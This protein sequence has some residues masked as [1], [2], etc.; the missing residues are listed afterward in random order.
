MIERLDHFVLT[1]ADLDRSIGFY[2]DVLG[3]TPRGFGEGR[4]ALHFGGQKINLHVAGKEFEPKARKPKPGSADLC[5]VVRGRLEDATER[6]TKAGVA[7][8]LGP[9]ERTGALAPFRSIYCRD[10]DG[11]LIELSVYG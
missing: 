3:M 7:I 5:F 8:E 4:M 1:V 9:V 2:R 6:L 11:N 10:P